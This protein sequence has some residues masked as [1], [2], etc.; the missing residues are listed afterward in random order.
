MERV[1][2]PCRPVRHRAGTA[3]S[4]KRDEPG[5]ASAA[6]GYFWLIPA[7]RCEA[8]REIKS[9]RRFR[10]LFVAQRCNSVC[11]LCA[12][13]YSPMKVAPSRG[14]NYI[15]NSVS[16]KNDLRQK[17]GRGLPIPAAYVR[18]YVS[19]REGLWLRG[20]VTVQLGE[21]QVD[22]AK[23]WAREASGGLQRRHP[24]PEC[25]DLLPGHQFEATPCAAR[26]RSQD[27]ARSL[28]VGLGTA[29]HSVIVWAGRFARKFKRSAGWRGRGK[30]GG[31]CAA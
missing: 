12:P 7:V 9:P 24:R 22:R 30:R 26:R 25:Y 29:F 17:E 20:R 5:G 6:R 13:R 31:S 16:V 11:A 14:P 23:N 3:W 19:V 1:L 21:A 27:P 10:G 18:R 2:G 15:G 8:G 4:R 28:L